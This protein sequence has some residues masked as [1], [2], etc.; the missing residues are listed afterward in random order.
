[1]SFDTFFKNQ[2]ERLKEE[3]NY[4]YFA[5]YERRIDHFPS[6]TNHYKGGTREVKVRCSND[7]LGMGQHPKVISA[8]Q[9]AVG[10][11][12]AGAGGSACLGFHLRL[13]HRRAV[14]PPLQAI[15]NPVDRPVRGACLRLLPGYLLVRL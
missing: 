5:D 9:E 14:A 4:R 3:G 13:V 12:G 6:A 10:R 15:H 7:Y 1:M 8:M 11:S 2:I